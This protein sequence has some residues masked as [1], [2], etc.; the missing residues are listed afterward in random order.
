MRELIAFLADPRTML[1]TAAERE[2]LHELGGGCQVP[3]GA[4][5]TLRE[6]G[7]LRLDGLIS[8]LEGRRLLRDSLTARPEERPGKVLAQRMLAGGGRELLR[9]ILF[10]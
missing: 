4:L 1:E 10:R 6:D 7:A 3:I 8:D 9:E 2:F 5:A